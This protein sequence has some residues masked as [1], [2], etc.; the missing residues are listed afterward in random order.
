MVGST[1]LKLHEWLILQEP[2]ASAG[3]RDSVSRMNQP[4]P[5]ARSYP[6]SHPERLMLSFMSGHI[7]SFIK[8]SGQLS[9]ESILSISF[10]LDE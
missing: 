1:G 8:Y 4:T 2:C 5:G 3:P 7:R 6:P 9:H 10:E